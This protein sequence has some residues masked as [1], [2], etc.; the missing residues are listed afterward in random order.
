MQRIM[1]IPWGVCLLNLSLKIS[2]TSSFY[3]KPILWQH[4]SWNN[5]VVCRLTKA[6][7]VMM[8]GLVLWWRL[9]LQG[10]HKIPGLVF[11][12]CSHFVMSGF[13][14]EIHPH[15]ES[16]PDVFRKLGCFHERAPQSGHLC[17]GPF[18][19]EWTFQAPA[20][21]SQQANTIFVYIYFF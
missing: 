1:N 7:L 13:V 8:S 15:T 6:L 2:L 16:I 10:P 19:G 11:V 4:Y 18:N 21:D 20:L 9:L 3:E 12:I 5:T 17:F 14:H